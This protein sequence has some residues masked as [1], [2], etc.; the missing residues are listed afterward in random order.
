ME[1]K[2]NITFKNSYLV[3]PSAPTFQGHMPLSL[4]DQTGYLIHIPTVHFY[5]PPPPQFT[6]DGSLIN[7]LKSSLAMALVHF[8]PL[9]GRI[10][11]LEGGRMELNCNSAGAQLLEAV[12]R[13]T[14]DQIGD[15]SPS[16]LFHNLV[17]SLNYNDMKNLPLLVIQV[18]KFKDENIALGIAISHIIADG[19]SAFHFIIEWARLVSGNSIFTKPF[20]DRRVLRGDSRVPR[21]GGERIDVNSHAA[22]PHL[23]LPIVIGETSAKIQQE[24]KTSIDLLI[25]STKEIEFL[26]SL[27][28]DGIVPAMKR[29][30]STFE[31]ISAHLWR[32]ACRARLLI[33]EQPTVLS[34]PINFRKLIQPPLPVGYFGNAILDIRSMDFSGNLLTGTLANT[35]AKIRKTILAV[36]SE[37]LYSEIEFLQMQTDLSKFQERHDY[38][39]YL[40]NPNLTI[41]SWLTFPFNGLDFGWGKSL[42]MVEASH[43]GDGDFVLHGDLHGGVVVSMCFQE[44]YIKSFKYYFYEIFGDMNKKD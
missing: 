31:V 43:N 10:V 2:L 37:F 33:H 16:P 40:G 25:L 5:K 39:E 6:Q 36:T 20:L 24:K 15:L 19:Q 22:N 12:C 32:C 1:Q 11:L 38:M 29:P 27:A 14:L 13:E 44:E 30:Y 9:A 28:S 35:A 26:K 17:P 41:S 34:F 8:Y 3:K 21:S 18:T 7:K 4:F 42:G 23:P